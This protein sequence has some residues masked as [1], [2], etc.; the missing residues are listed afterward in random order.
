[1]KLNKKKEAKETKRKKKHVNNKK[2]VTIRDVRTKLRL[3]LLVTFLVKNF[4]NLFQSERSY[5]PVYRSVNNIKYY[6]FFI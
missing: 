6:Y 4:S 2:N 3:D 1:M 5:D